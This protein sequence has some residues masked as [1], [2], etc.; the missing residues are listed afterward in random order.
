MASWFIAAINNFQPELP[1]MCP[2]CAHADESQMEWMRFAGTI[3][4]G[5]SAVK[6]IH[7]ADLVHL[8]TVQHRLH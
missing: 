1:S 7:A 3:S 4:M 8:C 5:W 2:T 6:I